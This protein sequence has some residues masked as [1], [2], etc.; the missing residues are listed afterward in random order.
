MTP[1]TSTPHYLR[2]FHVPVCSSERKLL[3][4][5]FHHSDD[6]SS[7]LLHLKSFIL[8]VSAI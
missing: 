4:S 2:N 5:F 6:L 1:A 7:F 3:M 8:K